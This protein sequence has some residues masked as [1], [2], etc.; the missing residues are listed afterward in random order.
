MIDWGGF[1]RFLGVDWSGAASSSGSPIF[2]ADGRPDGDK[3]RVETLTRASS[4]RAVENFL[5]GSDLQRHPSWESPRWPAPRP[6]GSNEAVL[7]GLDFAFGFTIDFQAHALAPTDQWEWA[8]KADCAERLDEHLRRN[9]DSGWFKFTRDETLPREPFRA[10]EHAVPGSPASVFNLAAAAKQ[11]GRGSIRGMA[12]LHRIRDSACV[13]PFDTMERGSRT[14]PV[15]VEMY[16]AMWIDQAAKSHLPVRIEQA[17]RLCTW[18]NFGQDVQLAAAGDDDALDALAI[19]AG[20]CRAA[21]G[22]WLNRSL[23][24][25]AR[26]EGWIWGAEARTDVLP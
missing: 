24:F 19:L 20:F 18:L 16:P 11:V 3:I 13:W 8:A 2:V 4:R 7:V 22:A 9:C 6:L 26:Q 5:R 14:R 1:D 17:E 10:T 23:P 25:A 21:P 15:L 12:M